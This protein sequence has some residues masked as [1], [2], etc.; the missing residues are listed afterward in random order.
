MLDRDHKGCPR[1]PSS[2]TI[3]IVSPLWLLGHN[4]DENFVDKAVQTVAR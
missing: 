1:I 2:S 4:A 3:L